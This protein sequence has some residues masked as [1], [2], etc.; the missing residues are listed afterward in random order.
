MKGDLVVCHNNIAET[1]D[2]GVG[3]GGGGGDLSVKLC[4]KA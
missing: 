2:G 1:E 3:G 4:T